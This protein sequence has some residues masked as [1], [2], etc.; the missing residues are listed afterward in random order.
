MEHGEFATFESD[1]LELRIRAVL[2]EGYPLKMEDEEIIILDAFIWFAA[3]TGQDHWFA[4]AISDT[5]TEPW[6]M[7]DQSNPEELRK[8]SIYYGHPWP[9]I[10]EG[11]AHCWANKHRDA[12]LT[13]PHKIWLDMM[14]TDDER[15]AE[16]RD[17]GRFEGH[18]DLLETMSGYR[19]SMN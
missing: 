18:S 17:I 13:T 2:H 15:L 14:S 10:E 1:D 4:F 11:C 12:L 16:L 8:C 19:L 7:I 9:V 5:L 6:E 3:R